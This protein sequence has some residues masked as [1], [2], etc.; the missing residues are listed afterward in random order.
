MSDA[1]Q[2]AMTA[3]RVAMVADQCR[4]S[5]SQR[6][7][8]E[9][10]AALEVVGGVVPTPLQLAELAVAAKVAAGAAD[11]ATPARRNGGRVLL[12]FKQVAAELGFQSIQSVLNRVAAGHLTVVRLDPLPDAKNR[13]GP[14][15]IDSAEVDRLKQRISVAA[16]EAAPAPPPPPAVTAGRS[17]PPRRSKLRNQRPTRL[18]HY[19]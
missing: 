17:G 7:V 18:R 12:T 16:A 9:R 3:S 8:F 10:M 19:E 15:R 6:R 1:I 14:P 11:A 5:K 2:D 13:K 4:L